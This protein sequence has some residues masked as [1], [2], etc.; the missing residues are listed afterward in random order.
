MEAPPQ[1][2]DEAQGE[3]LT[4]T[5]EPW[6]PELVSLRVKLAAATPSQGWWEKW[7]I[8]RGHVIRELRVCLQCP[9]H[10]GPTGTCP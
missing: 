2:G 8:S 7:V 10:P 1:P 3:A 4:Q 9:H 5:S 6:H